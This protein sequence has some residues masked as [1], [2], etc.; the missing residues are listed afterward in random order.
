MK[1]LLIF[2]L[3]S[4]SLK[5]SETITYAIGVENLQY[6][7]HFYVKKENKKLVYKGFGRDIFDLFQEYYNT[8]EKIIAEKNNRSF[9][10]INFKYKPLPVKRLLT[11]LLDGRIDFKYPDN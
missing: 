9:L 7:P 10:K 2:L 8:E 5:A 1:F 6:A 4:F 11:S 3:F